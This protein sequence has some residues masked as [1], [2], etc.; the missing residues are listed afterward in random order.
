MKRKKL[1]EIISSYGYY[2]LRRGGNH[3]VYTNGERNEMIAR[4][5]EIGDELAKKII[6]RCRG[7][8]K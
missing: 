6:K 2:F 7:K 1:I 3:D 8:G 5:T 4:H